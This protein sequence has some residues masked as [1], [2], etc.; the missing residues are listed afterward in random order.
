MIIGMADGIVTEIVRKHT[1]SPASHLH[2]VTGETGQVASASWGAA[3]AAPP[4]GT[5]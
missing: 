4:G 2:E 3:G 5:C 1:I